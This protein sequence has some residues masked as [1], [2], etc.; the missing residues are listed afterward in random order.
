MIWFEFKETIYAI[1]SWDNVRRI[2]WNELHSGVD[3]TKS[4]N[5]KAAW[6]TSALL[7]IKERATVK[8]IRPDRLIKQAEITS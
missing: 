8:T 7:E 4:S 6:C 1:D 2:L 5:N 3:S